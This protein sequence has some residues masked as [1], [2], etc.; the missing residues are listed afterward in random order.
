MFDILQVD[1]VNFPHLLEVVVDALEHH[2]LVCCLLLHFERNVHSVTD[3]CQIELSINY[4]L[5]VKIVGSQRRLA[6]R[7]CLKCL[8]KASRHHHCELVS[9]RQD[10]FGSQ[11][12][13][14]LQVLDEFVFVH[15]VDYNSDVFVDDQES[16]GF[17]RVRPDIA[18]FSVLCRQ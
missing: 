1:K 10:P 9:L 17:E 13:L 8:D 15:G 4:V 5:R 16:M 14:A 18:N 7:F 12:L 6:S 3:L 2:R 11:S